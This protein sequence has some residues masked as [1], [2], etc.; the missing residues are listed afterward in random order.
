MRINQQIIDAIQ[1]DKLVL[2]IG[3]GFSKSLGLPDWNGLVRAFL[4]ELLNEDSSYQILL[5]GLESKKFFTEI[6]ILEKIKDHKQ[7]IYRIMDDIINIEKDHMGNLGFHK[8][9]GEISNKIITTNYDKSLEYANNYRKIIYDNDYHIANLSENYIL[10]LHGCIEDPAKCILFKDDYVELYKENNSAIERFKNIITD[11]T[12]LFIGFSFSDPF[13]RQQF[14]YIQKVYKGLSGNHFIITTEDVDFNAYGIQPLKIDNWGQAF[15]DLLTSLIEIKGPKLQLSVSME[16]L[17]PEVIAKNYLE[18]K[19]NIA[20]LL[21]SPVDKEVHY[22]FIDINKEFSRLQVNVD[23]FYLTQLNLR[24][25]DGYD[26]VFI[27]SNAYQEKILIEDKYLK[28]KYK[29][30]RDIEQ[31]IAITGIKCIFIILDK[32]INIDI[33]DF[34]LPIIILWENEISNIL[35]KLFKKTTY[36]SLNN[37]KI[38]NSEKIEISMIEKGVAVINEYV[39]PKISIDDSI[40]PKK[41]INFVGRMTDIEDIIQKIIDIN[42]NILTIKGSGGIGKTT[43]LKKAVYELYKRRYFCDGYYFIDC[44]FILDFN[45]FEYKVSQCFGIDSSINLKDHILQNEMKL[46]MLI[47]FDNFETMLYII[48]VDKIKDLITFI[49]EYATLVITS[50]EWVGFEFEKRHELRAFTSDEAY[51]LFRKYYHSSINEENIKI[52][53]EEILDNLLNNN[54]LAIKII[55]QNL[56]KTK[57]MIQL[58]N[59]LDLDFFN[60]TASGYDDIFNNHGDKNIERSKSLFQSIYYSY[61]KLTNREKLL[62]EILALFPDGIHMQNLKTFFLKDE[63]KLNINKVTDREITSLENKSLIEINRGFIKLQSI[64]GRFAEYQFNTRSEKEKEYYYELSFNYISHIIDSIKR[65][66]KLQRS[67]GHRVFDMNSKNIM[68]CFEYIT[69]FEGDKNK[70][71]DFLMEIDFFSVER[72]FNHYK[73]LNGLKSYFSEIPYAESL[74]EIYVLKHQFYSGDF[75]RMYNKLINVFPLNKLGNYFV[76]DNVISSNFV[77]SVLNVY[78]YS[79]TFQALKLIIKFDFFDNMA[80]TIL[81][82]LGY[83]KLLNSSKMKELNFFYFEVVYNSGEINVAAL[84]IYINQLYETEFIE[85]MQTHYIKAKLGK[86]N[87]KIVT[88]LV[89]TNPYTLGLKDLML[90]FFEDDKIKAINLYEK[91]ISELEHIKY[92]YVEAIYF[93]TKFLFMTNLEGFNKWYNDGNEL[94]EK[95]QYMYLIYKFKVLINNENEIYNEDLYKSKNNIEI[96]EYIEHLKQRI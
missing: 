71:I 10:K 87:K 24:D 92:Y 33:A 28:S 35:F 44:E 49:C 9:L 81:F 27:F 96:D 57:D 41:L 86:T 76:D 75:K 85:I 8:K 77:S 74:I 21:P 84:D 59:E 52:L 23:C 65:L 39:G 72:T 29:Q 89:A 32:E 91:A 60:I 55:A 63:Y 53:K 26:Y 50:R 79:D 90:A 61:N 1:K 4:I 2:F 15:D 12:I 70:K 14:E 30:L 88:K 36:E 82:E 20:I 56:P 48:E 51:N 95:Y 73:K 5:D 18:Q 17:T 3:S 40:D 62:F 93:Y 66:T 7:L 64:L 45:T 25:L 13:V 42:N 31:D 19:N 11:K 58:K 6:E 83:Y 38:I 16:R 47:M 68:K 46:D 34:S 43:T 54:P 80:L 67:D 78:M 22:N 69:S 37:S 94:A